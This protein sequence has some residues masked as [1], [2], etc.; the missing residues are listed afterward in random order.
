MAK[1]HELP[2]A[3]QQRCISCASFLTLTVTPTGEGPVLL[4]FYQY[5]RSGLLQSG[6]C[7]LN[8]FPPLFAE[9]P[10]DKIR[11]TTGT[12]H[13]PAEYVEPKGDWF[14]VLLKVW[15]ESRPPTRMLFRPEEIHARSAKGPIFRRATDRAVGVAHHH[16]GLHR[17]HLLI[18]HFHHDRLATIQ[19]RRI[20]SDRLAGE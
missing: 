12:E 15:I 8:R 3:A 17:K 11:P 6:H 18:A 2:E 1:V 13:F 5:R 9:Q 19:T 14:Q 20:N 10:G 16:L 4:L 7:A